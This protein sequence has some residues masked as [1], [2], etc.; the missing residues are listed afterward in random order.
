MSAWLGSD[1]GKATAH[2]IQALQRV[3]QPD[4]IANA[5]AFLAGP[6]GAWVTGTIINASGGTKL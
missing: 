6:D 5:I 1:E 3:G 4:D 2:S